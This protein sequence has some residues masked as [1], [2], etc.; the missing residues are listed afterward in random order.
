LQLPF[1]SYY[2]LDL[3]APDIGIAITGSIMKNTL[4]RWVGVI[5]GTFFIFLGF[6]TVSMGCDTRENKLTP[7]R[8]SMSEVLI[9]K[10]DRG[11]TVEAKQGDVIVI[12]LEENIAAGY[13]W[14]IGRIESSIVELLESN[15]SP[16]SEISMG[17]GGMRILRLKAKSSGNDHGNL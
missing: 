10:S 12:Q 4:L 11:R 7:E 3:E 5:L 13:V 6:N 15:Y 9:T 8:F 14:E 1:S 2:K 17:S 16:N